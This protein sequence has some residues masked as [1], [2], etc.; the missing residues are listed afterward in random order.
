MLETFGSRRVRKGRLVVHKVPGGDNPADLM[1]KILT[2]K[3]VEDR[4][5]M[6]GI[7]VR[8]T[9]VCG[10]VDISEVVE[11]LGLRGAGRGKRGVRKVM[12]ECRRALGTAPPQTTWVNG[13]FYSGITE[14]RA[15]R[16]LTKQVAWLRRIIEEGITS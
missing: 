13:K 15:L 2:T 14:D 3:E 8:Y 7:R 6:M 4:H 10:A 9:V 12:A 5:K 1:T 16:N 11:A